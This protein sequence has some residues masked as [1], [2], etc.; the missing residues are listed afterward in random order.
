MAGE[1]TALADREARK[2]A[3]IDRLLPF[4]PLHRVIAR[5]VECL[6]ISDVER[7][8]PSLDLGCGDGT[9]AYAL[10]GG[11]AAGIERILM[12]RDAQASRDDEADE[13]RRR[14]YLALAS[15]S[16]LGEGF[17]FVQGL[18]LRG[19]S[20]SMDFDGRSLKAQLREAD[21]GGYRFVAILGED[22]LEQRAMTLKDLEGGQQET[23]GFD[24]FTETV[25]SR[26]QGSA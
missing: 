17:R 18:R 20:A 6:I 25:A 4:V 10:G 12:A 2:T 22:E 5:A 15:P 1:K 8:Q 19:V 24:V 11:F 14:L 9:F 7:K 23:V 13:P 21:K 3:Y 26:L 16:L